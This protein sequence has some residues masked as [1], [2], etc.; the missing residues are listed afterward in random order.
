MRIP[1]SKHLETFR[2]VLE[3]RESTGRKRLS[4]LSSELLKLKSERQLI[5]GEKRK[6]LELSVKQRSLS[7]SEQRISREYLTTSGKE[8]SRKLKSNQISIEALQDSAAEVKKSVVVDGSKL[9]KLSEIIRRGKQLED[10]VCDA[11]TNDDFGAL[12]AI[13]GASSAMSNCEGGSTVTSQP[14]GSLGSETVS[15]REERAPVVEDQSPFCVSWISSND[16]KVSLTVECAA[17]GLSAGLSSDDRDTGR[18][19]L[20]SRDK[21][22]GRVRASG[23]KISEI[24]ISELSQKSEDQR[25]D[26]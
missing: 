14:N 18:A 13:Q 24:R 12:R 6:L 21:L 23:V 4:K 20:D 17:G 25:D 5:Q 8:I 7:Y 22:I 11:A 19:L 2:S 3:K 9:E 10:A 15:S 1:A 26:E 16:S